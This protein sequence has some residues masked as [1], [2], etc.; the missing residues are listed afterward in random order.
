MFGCERSGT[1]RNRSIK[2]KRLKTRASGTKK[3]GCPFALRERKLDTADDWMLMVVCGVHNHSATEH[4]EGHSYAGRLS[5]QETS[6]LV[7][8]LKSLVD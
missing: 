7:D 4:L 5:K 8:M 3:C 1:H 6:L 2:K